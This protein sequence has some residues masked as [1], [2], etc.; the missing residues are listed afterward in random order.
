M[1]R[2]K[3]MVQK[4]FHPAKNSLLE[5]DLRMMRLL[6]IAESGLDAEDTPYI[7]LRSGEIF[8]SFLPTKQE[9]A[10][11]AEY[12]GSLPNLKKLPEECFRVAMDVVQ[13]FYRENS[14]YHLPPKTHHLYPRWGFID[15]GAY[16]G[17]GT[18]KA[19]RQISKEGV[20]VAVEAQP[21][22]YKLLEKNIKNNCINNVYPVHA[23]VGDRNG[24]LEL[25]GDD[26]Q[27]NSIHQVLQDQIHHSSHQ[28]RK[29]VSVPAKTLDTILEEVGY[30]VDS[31]STL[32]SLEIN[33]AEAAALSGGSHFLRACPRFDLRIAAR[34]G[35]VGDRKN[36][37]TRILDILS[38]YPDVTAIDIEPYVFAYKYNN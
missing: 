38:A 10:L 31:M 37:N 30:P 26:R 25:F 36:S 6:D 33:G 8:C 14:A 12:K 34:Y 11:Y 28:Y 9:L 20:V 5:I 22:V 32:V 13:R 16:I 21:D 19:A 29:S 23:A 4:L 24:T 7:R 15:L 1:L 18:I 35:G 3:R 17:F 27:S 2:L